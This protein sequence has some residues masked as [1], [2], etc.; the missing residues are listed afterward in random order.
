M[1]DAAGFCVY[2]FSHIGGTVG[3]KMTYTDILGLDLVSAF[4]A[5]QTSFFLKKNVFLLYSYVFD[6]CQFQ[7]AENLRRNVFS[8]EDTK[9]QTLIDTAWV[10]W[11][12]VRS[13]LFYGLLIHSCNMNVRESTNIVKSDWLPDG[14]RERQ[15]IVRD[16]WLLGPL[17]CDPAIGFHKNIKSKIDRLCNNFNGN[18]L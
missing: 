10:F 16:L 18:S 14:I 9:P 15:H 7:V 17:N 3:C 8:V 1:R 11:H 13:C 5:Q 2:F 4:L 12:F 6:I